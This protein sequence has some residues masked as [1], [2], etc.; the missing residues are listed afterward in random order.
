[1]DIK[2]YRLFLTIF[3][4]LFHN[5]YS[6]RYYEGPTV[7]FCPY[8]YTT[9]N[10]TLNRPFLKINGVPANSDK[11]T[12][13]Y[14]A[15]TTP[16]FQS[17]S[18]KSKF[19]NMQLNGLKTKLLDQKKELENQISKAWW[20]KKIGTETAKFVHS[21]AIFKALSIL[22]KLNYCGKAEQIIDKINTTVRT[23]N[24][25]KTMLATT[26]GVLATAAHD[27]KSTNAVAA[28]A[29][30]EALVPNPINSSL[31]HAEQKISQAA[32]Q[33]SQNL[34]PTLNNGLTITKELI[35]D[36]TKCSEFIVSHKKEIL[37]H[38]K[39]SLKNLTTKSNLLSKINPNAIKIDH[40][41]SSNH[42]ADN[43]LK[44]DHAP[45]II[46]S[47]K[48]I[49]TKAIKMI[50]KADNQNLL[51]KGPNNIRTYF[52]NMPVEIH[53]FIKKDTVLSIDTFVGH[54]QRIV[55]NLIE[56]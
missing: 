4:C 39:E 25:E 23:G 2:K 51:Q 24:T 34:Q 49:T 29:I 35:A 22:G 5:I 20:P 27:I 37:D 53:I 48:N 11:V 6:N 26:Q 12:K 15:H 28:A 46:E 54:S 32:Q 7:L 56:I 17:T 8:G 40:I 13:P 42:I 33:V 41:F 19:K 31:L 44:I 47:A 18:P 38:V 30:Q 55:K 45:G 14:P 9:K 1:M 3:L 16:S 52:N 43:I 36:S 21:S 10:E 50:K